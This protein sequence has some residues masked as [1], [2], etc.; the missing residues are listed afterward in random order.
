MR[1]LI[2]VSADLMP[3]DT[4]INKD[5]DVAR[6]NRVTTHLN[7]ASSTREDVSI[8]GRRVRPDGTV[9]PLEMTSAFLDD[10]PDGALTPAERRIVAR[11]RE[12]AARALDAALKEKN[13]G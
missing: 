2:Q 7:H 8:I 3:R 9:S 4:T 12:I 5:G 10:M 6:I 1:I 13:R 11:T